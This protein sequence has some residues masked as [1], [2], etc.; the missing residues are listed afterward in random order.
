MKKIIFATN[1]AHKLDEIRQ[2]LKDSFD[3]LGL[4]DIGFTGD[5]PETGTTLVENAM[6]KSQFVYDR[7]HVDCF[8]D[9]TGLEIDALDYF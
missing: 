9:D 2:I 7:Y 8:S 3:V 6:I 1:N 5:I 4:K